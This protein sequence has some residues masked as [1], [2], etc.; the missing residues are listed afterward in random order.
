MGA[1][2]PKDGKQGGGDL[3]EA[4]LSDPRIRDGLAHLLDRIDA[5]E[6]AID[7]LS[8]AMQQGP[9]MVAMVADMADEQI[10]RAAQRGVYFDDRLQNTLHLLEKLTADETVKQLEGLLDL[11]QRAPG[12]TAMMAD[13]A[14]DAVRQ[15]AARGVHMDERLHNVLHLLEKLTE[16]ATVQQLENLLELS[17]QAPGLMAMLGDMADDAV[18]QAAQNGVDLD[19]RL[20][21]G[22][23][24][25]ERLTA[26]ST[27]EQLDTLLTLAERAPGIV[28]MTADM[29]DEAM[30]KA[31]AE[32]LDP[33]AVGE[34]L[35]QTTVALSKARQAPPK[36]VGLF[37]LM[38]AL[39]DPDRQKALGFLMNFLKE[40]GRNL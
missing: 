21:N 24:A 17:K 14:D 27:I 23:Y 40:L 22:L 6:Q 4:R 29:A 2:T 28:A 11:A 25:L 37:G 32:G 18:R 12:L 7:R 15:A 19:A 35:K 30:A 16:D 9:G 26:D 36:K 5:L 13:M 10:G 38:G 1:I 39:K 20:R 34:M 31:Q 3:L 33:Q 8:V